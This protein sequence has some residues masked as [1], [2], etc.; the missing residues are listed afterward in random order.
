MVEKIIRVADFTTLPGGRWKKDG[1]NSG[2]EFRDDVL[3]PALIASRANGD[4]VAVDIDGVAGYASSF[5]EETFGGIVRANVMP[6]N[7]LAKLLFVRSQ[8]PV[9]SGFQSDAMRYFQAALKQS[10]AA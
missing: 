1:P 3:K 10:Q 2:E 6:A 7:V 8:D 9:F 5:L 4:T